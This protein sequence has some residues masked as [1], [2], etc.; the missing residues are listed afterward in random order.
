MPKP[1]TPAL[2][3]AMVIAESSAGAPPVAGAA[4]ARMDW[5]VAGSLLGAFP[6][7]VRSRPPSSARAGTRG[8]AALAGGELSCSRLQARLDWM[9]STATKR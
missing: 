4:R 2:E 9:P 1:A 3:P 7:T 5:S 8:V 6:R